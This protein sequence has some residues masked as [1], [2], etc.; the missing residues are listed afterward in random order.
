MR[1]LVIDDDP[2]Q[3]ELVERALSREGFEVRCVTTAAQLGA[4]ATRFAPEIVL[5]DVNMPDAPDE[6][7]VGIA[8]DA[9]PTARVVLYSAWDEA[10][11]RGLC[12]KLG[13]DGYVSKSES[14]MAIGKRLRDLS[15]R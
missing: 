3:L 9:A 15:K 8:R 2:L 12:A 7:T 4:E 14:V 5:M 1:V 10:K 13:G 11:L 6:K